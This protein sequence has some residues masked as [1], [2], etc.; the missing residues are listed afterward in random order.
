MLQLSIQDYEGKNTV[1]PLAD[2]ELSIGRDDSNSICLTERNV[3]RRHAVIMTH[4]TKVYLENVAATFGTR[5]NNTFVRERSQLQSGD[6]V[7]IGDYSLQVMG[8]DEVKRDTA[9]VDDGA[10]PSAAPPSKKPKKKAGK[11]P[12]KKAPPVAND[13]TSVVRL[14][15]IQMGLKEEVGAGAS[16]PS[17]EQPRLVVESDNLRGWEGRIT[18]SPTVV[19]R[20]AENADLVVDHRSISKEHARLTRKPDGSWEILDLGS[21]NGIKV[22]GEPY[23]KSA[24]QSGDTVVLGHVTLRF[25]GAG[26]RTPA[27]SANASGGKS[28]GKGLL[29]GAIA[30]LVLLAGAGLAFVVLKSSGDEKKTAGAEV[31]AAAGEDKKEDSETDKGEDAPPA[32]AVPGKD[33][34]VVAD[35]VRKVTKLEKA[36]ML[37]ES[38]AFATDALKK[39]PGSAELSLLVK[40]LQSEKKITAR[41]VAAEKKLSKDP[42]AV[43]DAMTDIES[44]AK[45]MP[46]LAKKVST[47]KAKASAMVVAGLA[48]DAGKLLKRR[49]YRDAMEKAE[50]CQAMD[51]GNSTCAGILLK[52]KGKTQQPRRRQGRAAAT[53]PARAAK[54]IAKPARVVKPAAKAAPPADAPGSAMS[55]KDYYKAGRKAASSGD[56]R[57]AVGLFEKAV[58]KGYKRAHGKLARLYFQLGNKSKC[59]FHGKKY[60]NRY[61]D[62]GDAPAIEGLVEKCK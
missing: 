44:D 17:A 9:L 34:A 22:N 59:A 23:S 1:I 6:V 46:T 54:P 47:L 10:Q 38:I 50:M 62:A 13:K 52:A 12:S 58:S 15:D 18:R 56:N 31:A 57:K 33:H 27:S 19:G 32:A 25:L 26:E 55:A 24:I 41:F 2:G 36:G 21:A 4:G 39:H 29:V 16:I 60:V 7:Q 14:A 42:K 43:L 5:L 49:K 48:Q 35:V 11:K 28:G 30:L 37:D 45:G 20:V 8:A 40:R 53:K 51:P 61:P 3:S